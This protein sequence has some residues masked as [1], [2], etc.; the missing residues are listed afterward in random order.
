MD[1]K[2]SL[3]SMRMDNMLQVT[4]LCTLVRMFRIRPPS[5]QS[6]L[7]LVE[8]DGTGKLRNGKKNR[9]NNGNENSRQADGGGHWH[10]GPK[11]AIESWDWEGV[12][13]TRAPEGKTDPW[14]KVSNSCTDQLLKHVYEM[15]DRSPRPPFL[16]SAD[17]Q[18]EMLQNEQNTVERRN[19]AMDFRDTANRGSG[20]SPVHC[21][22]EILITLQVDDLLQMRPQ[23]ASASSLLDE[24]Q[25]FR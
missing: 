2:L 7:E 4:H 13:R 20:T 15:A 1:D 22:S 6:D 25:G 9:Y 23:G 11:M 14:M 21:H 5:T 3:L 10:S 24:S 18:G 16:G 17:E 8:G 19:S 12:Q